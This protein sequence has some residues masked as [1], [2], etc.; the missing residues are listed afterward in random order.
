VCFVKRRVVPRPENEDVI[1]SHRNLKGDA[2]PPIWYV[3]D[4]DSLFYRQCLP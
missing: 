3:C 2:R 4:G 1:V